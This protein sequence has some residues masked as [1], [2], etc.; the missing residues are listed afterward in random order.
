MNP[1]Y[2]GSRGVTRA[3]ITEVAIL[4]VGTAFLASAGVW[5]AG[6]LGVAPGWRLA[7]A[8]CI[9]VLVVGSGRLL[10]YRRAPGWRWVVAVLA[11]WGMILASNALAEVR[12]W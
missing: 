2:P 5:L 3:E 4:A 9:A 10:Y 6:W 1:P 7:V 12:F 11:I 8:L